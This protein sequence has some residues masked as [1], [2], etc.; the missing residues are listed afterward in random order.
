MINCVDS[1]LARGKALVVTDLH[2]NLK[3]YNQYK[4]IWDSDDPDFHLV[5]TGDFIH[6]MDKKD[7]SIE[8]LHD[9]MWNSRFKDNFHVL[10]GNHEWTHIVDLDIYKNGVNQKKDFEELI[11]EKYGY[12]QPLFLFLF[13]DFFKKLPLAVKTAN[14]LF[15]SH[16]GPAEGIKSIGDVENLL[17]SE[18]Y[19]STVVNQFLWSRYGDYSQYDIDLFLEAVDCKA[20]IVGHTVVDG[21]KVIGNQ[22]ILSSSYGNG[23]KAYLEI[24]LGKHIESVDDVKEMVRYLE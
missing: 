15:I 18:D 4:D 22:M 16:S 2:G 14:G 6:S 1:L 7:G 23:K 19:T 13:L 5:I 11:K 10:L 8:I 17:S 21:V 24:D 9:I 20:M 3:D 12:L